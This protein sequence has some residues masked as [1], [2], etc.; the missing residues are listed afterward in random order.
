MSLDPASIV[1]KV[2]AA[3]NELAVAEQALDTAITD[4]RARGRAE[5]EIIGPSLEDAFSRLQ[6]AR[7]ALVDLE[8]LLKA[9]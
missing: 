2:E 9:P 3:K 5:K 6:A 8:L 1:A 7:A 4:L